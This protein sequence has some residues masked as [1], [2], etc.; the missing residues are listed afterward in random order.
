MIEEPHGADSSA[1]PD[2]AENLRR[3]RQP[4]PVEVISHI[5]VA[6]R[7]YNGLSLCALLWVPVPFLYVRSVV[8]LL[9][10]SCFTYFT[11]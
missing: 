10:R 4:L 11:E 1:N 5:L 3:Q 8:L 7:K 9:I 2:R 6:T